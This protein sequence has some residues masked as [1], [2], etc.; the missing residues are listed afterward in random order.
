MFSVSSFISL[1]ICYFITGTVTDLH[2]APSPS[3]VPEV[4][5][6]PSVHDLQVYGLIFTVILCLIVFGGVKIINRVSPAF[7]IPVILSLFFIYIGIFAARRPS[8]PCMF[9]HSISLS[10]S[11]HYCLQYCWCLAYWQNQWIFVIRKTHCPPIC[12]FVVPSQVCM[13]QR[14]CWCALSI[15][16]WFGFF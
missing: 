6:S 10:L 5:K 11:T 15:V 13:S 16:F 4:L 14:W 7:L 2:F 9:S 3:A 12:S 8:D 1:E